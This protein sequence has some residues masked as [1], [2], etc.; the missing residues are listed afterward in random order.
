MSSIAPIHVHKS[1][2]AK[3]KRVRILVG[4]SITSMARG[5]GRA[6]VTSAFASQRI[7]VRAWDRKTGNP[8]PLPRWLC[9]FYPPPVEKPL[10]PEPVRLTTNGRPI[11]GIA[12]L[13]PTSVLPPS[14]AQSPAIVNLAEKSAPD[15]V[16]GKLLAQFNRM[17]RGKLK[18]TPTGVKRKY[19]AGPNDRHGKRFNQFPIVRRAQKCGFCHNC[20]RPQLRQA[21]ITR[22]KEMLLAS[23]AA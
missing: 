15:S 21:C 16:E 11:G 22:R 13:S 12:P 8:R 14:V 2:L 20:L 17:F 6:Q 18:T 23:N 3:C 4:M 9:P 5:M 19:S 10:E 1:Q 7:C